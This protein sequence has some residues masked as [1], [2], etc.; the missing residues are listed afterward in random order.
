MKW[1]SVKDRMPVEDTRF[2]V[3]HDDGVV[4]ISRVING[5]FCSVLNID[6]ERAYVTHWMPLPEPPK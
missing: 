1:I 6:L 3:Y 4:R 5:E 2:L